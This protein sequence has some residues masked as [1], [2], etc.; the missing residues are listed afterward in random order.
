MFCNSGC[1]REYNSQLQRGDSIGRATRLATGP[2]GAIAELLLGADLLNRGFSVFRAL[3][4]AAP[5]DLILISGADTVLRIEVRMTNISPK[6]GAI[7]WSTKHQGADLF[8]LYD[9]VHKRCLYEPI[10]AIGKN[11]C[12]Q[13]DLPRHPKSVLG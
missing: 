6:T 12:E 5:V 8:A 13:F 9:R 10:T 11:F 2:T 7:Y 3:S 1:L 4:P